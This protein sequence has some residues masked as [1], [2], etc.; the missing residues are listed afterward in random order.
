[1]CLCVCP[2]LRW[3]PSLS[4][5]VCVCLRL[6]VSE[7]AQA[8]ANNGAG[9]QGNSAEH[10]CRP[11]RICWPRGLVYH[12]HRTAHMCVVTCRLRTHM[13]LTH[14]THSSI[15]DPNSKTLNPKRLASGHEVGCICPTNTYPQP[16]QMPNQHPIHMR[17]YPQPAPHTIASHLWALHTSGRDQRL[18][19]RASLRPCA[20]APLSLIS[21][22]I[23]YLSSLWRCLVAQS[24]EQMGE[25]EMRDER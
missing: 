17:P 15:Q 16:A 18:F 2:C 23:S 9:G 6:S 8:H 1:M 14:T 24:E 25:K 7:H 10:A 4:V 13:P 21:C 3:W 12:P 11:G 5:S 19:R 22:L 20:V